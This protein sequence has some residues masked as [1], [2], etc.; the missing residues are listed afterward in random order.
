MSRKRTF[1]EA[2]SP[3]A[4][5]LHDQIAQ[6]VEGVSGVAL[7]LASCSRNPNLHQYLA[8]VINEYLHTGILT[9]MFT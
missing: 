2:D 4:P 3:A 9:V 5:S 6:F 8:A 7:A 1:P